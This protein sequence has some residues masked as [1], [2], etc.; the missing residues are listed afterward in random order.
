MKDAFRKADRSSKRRGPPG[1][2]T[3]L[4]FLSKR[5]GNDSTKRASA[6]KPKTRIVH[7]NPNIGISCEKAIVYTIPPTAIPQVTTPMANALFALK[8]ALTNA[9]LGT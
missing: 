2:D 5:Q 3:E 7:P 4:G 1:V 8:L 9:R 6:M